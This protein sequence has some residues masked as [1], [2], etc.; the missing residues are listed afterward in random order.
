LFD[1]K[2]RVSKR[3]KENGIKLLVRPG[4]FGTQWRRS[5]G[6]T[7]NLRHLTPERFAT[8]PRV[9]GALAEEQTFWY[10]CVKTK[11]QRTLIRRRIV[12]PPK[13]KTP[14]KKINEIIHH[15]S[16]LQR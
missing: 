15:H 8:L 10:F 5:P 9:A 13:S 1:G 14:L 2:I 11:V 12:K 3:D 6:R 4:S 7:C 16:K